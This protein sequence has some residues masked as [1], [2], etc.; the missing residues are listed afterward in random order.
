[1]EGL[2]MSDNLEARVR[3]LEDYEAIRDTW[4]DYLFN[5][6]S[7]NW[8]AFGEVFT[9]NAI[10]EIVG[11]GKKRD[12]TFAGRKAIVDWY[13]PSQVTTPRPGTEWVNGAHHGNSMK[14]EL[15][16]D[17]ATTFAYFFVPGVDSAFGTYQH[18]M[19]R[20]ADGWRIAYLRVV[21]RYHLQLQGRASGVRKTVRDVLTMPEV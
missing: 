16:G 10:V 9:E 12:G 5:L 13:N 19:R 2:H 14:I 7:E 11:M 4:C 20:T 15:D 18:R 1:M 17:E 6:D 8:A 3:R 21:I